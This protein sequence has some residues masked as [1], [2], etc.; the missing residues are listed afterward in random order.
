[1]P[2]CHTCNGYVT[3]NY[4]RVFAAMDADFVRACPDCESERQRRS[5]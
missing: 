3:D 2:R 1:M 4:V 5:T